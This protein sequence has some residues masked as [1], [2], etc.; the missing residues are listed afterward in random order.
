VNLRFHVL[1]P[2]E[3]VVDGSAVAV[4][5]PRAGSILS[6]L[7][8]EAGAI[9]SR[10]RLI[11]EVWADDPPATAVTA[12]QV[13]ISGLRKLV[14]EALRT[15]GA[16]YALQ[17]TPEQV[18]AARF[19]ALLG[20][21]GQVEDPAGR[22]RLARAALALWRGDPFAGV[23]QVPTVA[24][25]RARLSE[26]RLQAIEERVDADLALGRHVE[27]AAELTEL[28]IANPCRERLAGQ[29]MLALHRAG[30]SADAI[31]A[32]ARVRRAL[33]EELGVGLGSGLLALEQAIRRDDPEL[34]APPPIFLPSPQGSFIGRRRELAD[35]GDLLVRTRLLTLVGPGGCGKTRLALELARR[36]LPDHPDGTRF[37]DLASLEPAASVAAAVLVEMDRR[38]RSGET[39]AEALTSYLRDRRF[40]LLLDNCERVGE[41]CGRLVLR[42]LERCPGLRVLVTSR[43]PLGL[44]G[45]VVLRVRGLATPPDEASPDDAWSA[46]AVRLLANRASAA[47][48]ARGLDPAV[49][50]A[51][52]RRVDGLPLAIELV[53]ARLASSSIEEIAAN[54]D[55]A[56][57]LLATSGPGRQ[58][59]H[60]T[61]RAAIDWSHALLDPEERAVFRR[62]SVLVG[63]FDLSAAEEVAADPDGEPPGR[64][65]DVMTVLFRLVD[66]SM[67]APVS[68]FAGRTRYRLLDTVREYA[69]EQLANPADHPHEIRTPSPRFRGDPGEAD[70]T[71]RRHAAWCVRLVRSAMDPRSLF[72]EYWPSRIDPEM[73][74][75]RAAVEWSLRVGQVEQ[76]MAIVAPLW[77]YFWLRGTA[78]EGREWLLRCLAAIDDT[79]TPARG[80]T[81]R[82]A[83]LLTM[84]GGDYAEARRLG[85]E[86]LANYRAVGDSRGLWGALNGL[87]LTAH[88]V[89][90]Y[91]RALAH[92]RQALELAER[93]SDSTSRT[94][95]LGGIGAVLRT[96]GR[97]DEAAEMLRTALHAAAEVGDPRTQADVLHNMGLLAAQVGDLDQARRRTRES[98]AAFGRFRFADGQLDAI[99]TLA[100]VEAADGRPFE[101]LRLLAVVDRER[102]LLAGAAM[103]IDRRRRREATLEAARA[104]LSA[105]EQAAAVASARLVSRED[106]VEELR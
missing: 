96:L 101:A 13:H 35:T 72:T 61:M 37:V 17:V 22:A 5:G 80:I 88:A 8:I 14:G 90:D 55:R 6:V 99:E 1:G 59:R 57:S 10:D 74:S 23:P 83:A 15:Y 7:L 104:A 56:L 45:E 54:L 91:E 29:L 70:R 62:L 47:A 49:A 4:G 24:A 87:G 52:C 48:P 36:T 11:D 9:V 28:S 43:Q 69:A 39:P 42:L 68:S 21:V 27:L 38:E 67:I 30:R 71:R 106:L 93:T 77:P 84:H 89:G 40:L 33:Q 46:D 51:V 103:S 100:S 78:C 76:A 82:A 63:T 2:L 41:A 102:A 64:P 60:R 98:V 12:L 94:M 25:A 32:L 20:E 81:L 34:A 75:L 105:D 97:L 18:D 92:L 85:E 3:A 58:P 44:S 31:A 66:K 19:E 79:P 86:C 50:A 95:T 16:G 26:L 53:A 65:A 73:A